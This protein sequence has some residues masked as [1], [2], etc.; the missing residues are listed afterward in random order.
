MKIVEDL[1]YIAAGNSPAGGKNDI[2][3]RLKRLFFTF[4]MIPPS[5][6]TIDSIY[7]RILLGRYTQS[8][9]SKKKV[10]AK[11]KNVAEACRK[12]IGATIKLWL[13]TKKYFM[14]TPSKFHYIFNMRDLSRIF[15]GVMR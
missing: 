8:G 3:H 10:T 12:T 1:R 6:S 15:Q 7:G 2:P 13:W 9:D 14:P 5:N 11:E 4:N